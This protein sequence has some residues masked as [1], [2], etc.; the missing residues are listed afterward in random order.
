M[1]RER[2]AAWTKANAFFYGSDFVER[3]ST[4]RKGIIPLTFVEENYKSAHRKVCALAVFRRYSLE[5]NRTK[6]GRKTRRVCIYYTK[7]LR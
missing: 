4:P 6:R 5:T 7:G 3:C 2:L 1:A